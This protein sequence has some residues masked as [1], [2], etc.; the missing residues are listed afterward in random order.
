MKKKNKNTTKIY[1]CLSQ[2]LF[3]FDYNSLFNSL[4]EI[5]FCSN[6]FIRRICHYIFGGRVRQNYNYFLFLLL[7]MTPDTPDFTTYDH[8]V[9]LNAQKEMQILLG[10]KFIEK[11][12]PLWAKKGIFCRSFNFGYEFEKSNTKL[13]GI[14]VEIDTPADFFEINNNNFITK[15]ANRDIDKMQKAII[16]GFMIMRVFIYDVNKSTCRQKIEHLKTITSDYDMYKSFN[17]VTSDYQQVNSKYQIYEESLKRAL[18][19]FYHVKPCDL[20]A[21]ANNK[22]PVILDEQLIIKPNLKNMTPNERNFFSWLEKYYPNQFTW[23]F[24]PDWAINKGY[25]LRYDFVHKSIKFIIE[26][27]DEEHFTSGEKKIQQDFLKN[28]LAINNDYKIM[29]LPQDFIFDTNH[30]MDIRREILKV[31]IEK[32]LNN[33]ITDRFITFPSRLKFVNDIF[34]N[35]KQKLLNINIDLYLSKELKIIYE[36]ANLKDD[37]TLFA[38]YFTCN[39]KKEKKIKK[40]K[41]QNPKNSHQTT[42]EHDILYAN[43]IDWL[44][45]TFANRNNSKILETS[46]RIE[47]PLWERRLT[48]DCFQAGNGRKR[49]YTAGSTKLKILIGIDVYLFIETT[50]ESTKIR[51]KEKDTLSIQNG[52]TCIHFD[53]DLFNKGD[54]W[55]PTLKT[56]IDNIID[57]TETKKL[58][59]LPTGIE[60]HDNIYQQFEKEITS[61]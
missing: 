59:W 24:S 56:M 8:S 18:P 40:K 61:Q 50:H 14:I 21:F 36:N 58:L 23:Q 52:Y 37:A 17:W 49:A 48:L 2:G 51:E 34:E 44:N 20:F 38:T 26:L 9:W 13:K 53:Y 35:H 3:V 22:I 25:K 1:I 30:D 33:I 46:D 12:K 54:D 32:T 31:I 39:G 29:R 4:N 47:S 11:Y 7:Y 45:T 55:K 43:F 5:I 19:E 15:N 41:I 57:E 42:S 16:N 10:D 28:K 6:L 27:D 60:K